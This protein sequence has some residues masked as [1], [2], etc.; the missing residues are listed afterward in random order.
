MMALRKT[1]LTSLGLV[2]LVAATAATAASAWDLVI[3]GDSECETTP[4]AAFLGG[5]DRGRHSIHLTFLAH[6]R[7]VW[8]AG[9]QTSWRPTNASLA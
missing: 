2:L 6:S 9:P 8:S 7:V 3:Y 5:G 4:T 1:T